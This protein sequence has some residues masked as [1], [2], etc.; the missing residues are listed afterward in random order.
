MKMKHI[1]TFEAFV[2]KSGD[3]HGLSKNISIN[4]DIFDF[5][6]YNIENEN[7]NG[8]NIFYLEGKL[9]L[10][11]EVEE[12]EGTIIYDKTLGK[13]FYEFEPEEGFNDLL[14]LYKEDFEKF[15]DVIKKQLIR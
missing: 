14:K 15:C 11:P 13:F 3:I 7:E 5:D 2:D 4:S 10:K 9:Y 8:D 1:K 12:F 6:L